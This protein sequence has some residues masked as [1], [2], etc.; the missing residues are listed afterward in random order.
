MM[1]TTRFAFYR[2]VS[3]EDQQD[4]TSSKQWQRSRAES[5]IQPH[6]GVIVA[7]YFDIRQSRSLPWKRR[8]QAT[9]LLEALKDPRR[10]FNAIVIGEPA[11]A[12]YGEQFASPFPS[13]RTTESRCGSRR[14]AERSTPAARRTTS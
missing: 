6:G 12:F 11:R 1:S 10:G 2:R 5:L 7:A 8:P 9:A 4:P 14:S 13:S 3:T